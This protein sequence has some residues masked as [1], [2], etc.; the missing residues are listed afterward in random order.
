[1]ADFL[2]RMA[3]RAAGT[4][5]VVQPLVPT[6]FS[7]DSGIRNDA[8]SAPAFE[9]I[10][11]IR[12][13]SA[14]ELSR[15]STLPS[16]LRAIPSRK[17]AK[18][19]LP[20]DQD[21]WNK[22]DPAPMNQRRSDL[23]FA[24]LTRLEAKFNEEKTPAYL[25]NGESKSSSANAAKTSSMESVHPVASDAWDRIS[26]K[27]DRT[28]RVHPVETFSSTTRMPQQ[29]YRNVSEESQQPIIRVTIGRIDVRAVLSA[30]TDLSSVTPVKRQTGLSLDDY[31][32]QRSE[33]KR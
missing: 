25:E 14:L 21:Q 9:T 8:F 12:E 23:P 33:G 18:P 5:P 15:D 22:E 11:T 28:S 6:I 27:P 10:N 24:A 3:A 20:S 17:N 16:D 31:M 4:V 1:M 32:K 26:A 29:H 13:S 7:P 19:A 2:N 30:T